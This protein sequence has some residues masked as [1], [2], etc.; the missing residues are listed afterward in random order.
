MEDSAFAA[1]Y[2]ALQSS[3]LHTSIAAWAVAEVAR[4]AMALARTGLV[5]SPIRPCMRQPSAIKR[6]FCS[7]ATHGPETL[8]SNGSSLSVLRMNAAEPTP[9]AGMLMEAQ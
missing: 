2:P 8:H 7:A 5:V 1:Q 9:L 4:P 6:P 3:G